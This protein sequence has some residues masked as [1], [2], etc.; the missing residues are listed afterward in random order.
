MPLATFEV[1]GY[2]SRY[3]RSHS[4]YYREYSCMVSRTS[5][6]LPRWHELNITAFQGPACTMFRSAGRTEASPLTALGMMVD[7]GSG[8]GE[9]YS[10]MRSFQARLAHTRQRRLG[11]CGTVPEASSLG[12]HDQAV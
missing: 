3:G 7:G 11:R 6:E 4:R 8:S 2:V 1:W 12:V 9:R 10:T 5:C